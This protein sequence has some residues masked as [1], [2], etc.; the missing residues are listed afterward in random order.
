LEAGCG[1]GSSAL[2]LALHD[3]SSRV[4]ACDFSA[5]A[6]EACSSAGAALPP[7]RLCVFQADVAARDFGGRLRDA[8]ALAGWPCSRLDV[9]LC[10]FLLSALPPSEL[11]AAVANALSALVPRGLLLVRD[12]AELD[13][14]HLRFSAE[15]ARGR[16]LFQRADGT[17]AR[18]F[19]R[20]VL[21]EEVCAAAAA[22]G[23]RLIC[24]DAHYACVQL[25]NRAS[26]K[27]MRRAFVHA[28]FQM[29][30]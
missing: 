20:E 2:P 6:V 19:T 24:R 15:S 7:S 26:G 13:M 23:Y 10:V 29:E 27:V 16:A 22:A 9:A 14:T 12:Y 4:A 30:D 25:V 8:T 3:T 28:S 11:P 17:L 21:V 18:F 1:S 5:A